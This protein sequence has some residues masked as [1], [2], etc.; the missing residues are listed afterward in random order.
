M[1]TSA[2]HVTV[3]G[4]GPAGLAAAYYARRSGREAV[5]FEAASDV[6]GNCRTLR[7]GGH[8][9]DTG[10]HRF[11]DKIP[12]VI[13]EIRGLLGDDLRR[14]DA[15]SRIYTEG[16]YIDFPPSPL[17]LIR[18][19]DLQTLSRAALDWARRG[20]RE[21]GSFR[22]LAEARYG[23]TLARLFLL[24]YSEKLWG[25]PAEGL[26]PSVAGERLKGLDL[27]TLFIEALRGRRGKTRHLD[28]SFY[29]P[30]NGYGQIV[31]AVAEAIGRPRLRTDSRITRIAHE[32][33]RIT[34]VDVNNRMCVPVS[35]VVNTLPLPLSIRLLDPA[36][37]HEIIELADSLCFRH[38]RLAVLVVRR[39]RVSAN[40][41]I[42]FPDRAL[43]FTRLYEPKNRSADLSPRNET[44][45]VVE[46]PC[47]EEDALWHADDPTFLEEIV[48][49]LAATDVVQ[50]SELASKLSLR[51]PAAYPV[52]ELGFEDRAAR[53]MAFLESFENLY[54]VGRNARFAY[55]HL[56]DLF[57]DAR[58]TV[59]SIPP[60]PLELPAIA[61]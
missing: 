22:S 10:A 18:A 26:S 16:R 58:G 49:G 19:L 31:D 60:S 30:R 56:H 1:S 55:A 54:L 21:E 17:N 14:V 35:S 61:I 41:S 53:L 23:S 15:P 42:Y 4:G 44:L 24:N 37:P 6:G 39:E 34:H 59:A 3:L 52:L 47:F 32:S 46:T 7:F 29:Y 5:V 12:H 25:R 9:F 33:G 40:A 51:M 50:R 11:H 27:R 28:G 38:L 13:D 8:R 48:E 43:P 2:D 20:P 57:D 36:A 45:I